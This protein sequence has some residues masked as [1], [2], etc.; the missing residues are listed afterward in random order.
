VDLPA[1]E[2]EIGRPTQRV[3]P[4][5]Y[6]RA[7][8]ALLGRAI[9][10]DGS[11]AFVDANEALPRAHARIRRAQLRGPSCD[12]L[13]R[14]E[15]IGRVDESAELSTGPDEAI[16]HPG[17]LEGREQRARDH[18]YRAARPPSRALA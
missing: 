13:R 1:V 4:R 9:C 6:V 5:H 3:L 8:I 7:A 15:R 14:D 17:G 16:K 12:E 11:P 2:G 10:A 18:A